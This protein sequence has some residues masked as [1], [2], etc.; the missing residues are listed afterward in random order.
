MVLVAGRQIEL[1][2]RQLDVRQESTGLAVGHGILQNMTQGLE[3]HPVSSGGV[4]VLL[5]WGVH[6]T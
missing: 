5:L 3:L 1:I 4:W 6:A 2:R